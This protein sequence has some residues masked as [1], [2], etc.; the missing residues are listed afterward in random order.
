MAPA[1]AWQ[2]STA[3]SATARASL[4]ISDTGAGADTTQ[5]ARERRCHGKALATAMAMT[6]RGTRSDCLRPE[7]GSR[8]Q[9]LLLL[10]QGL[11]AQP[12]PDLLVLAEAVF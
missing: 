4:A 3:M 1:E 7:I 9:F 2:K 6:V 8:H 10:L 12:Q 11:R 5:L